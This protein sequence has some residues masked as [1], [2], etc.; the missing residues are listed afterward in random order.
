VGKMFRGR[1][2]PLAGPG[3]CR[4]ILA[5][6]QFLPILACGRMVYPFD[7]PGCKLDEMEFTLHAD[8]AQLTQCQLLPRHRDDPPVGAG[9][10]VFH[11]RWINDTPKGSLLLSGLPIDRSVQ[12]A[13]GRHGDRK[14][15]YVCVRVRPSVP[16]IAR[17]DTTARK[18]IFLLDTSRS[19]HPERFA[20]SMKLLQTILE[21][22][23]H[24]EHF[25]ILTFNVAA[26]WVEP[27]RWVANSRAER[28]RIFASLDGLRL[29]GATDLSVALEALLKPRFWLRRD[30]PV[31]C[32]LL[33]DG[34][35]NWGETSPAALTA[36]F[37]NRVRYP[38]R[39][40]CY[41]T[42]IGEDNAELFDELTR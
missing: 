18:A 10:L 2:A 27:G 29:E 19:E 15:C 16:V 3:Y 30:A 26:K 40:H 25:N 8:A 28:K 4:I 34:R 11:R 7:L 24:I 14:A 13:S 32:F 21:K 39:F 22:D 37:F 35:L 33:S 12:V 17:K 6:E 38:V 41:R 23:P 5:Y 1:V 36:S 31:D 9:R 42:G 20:V